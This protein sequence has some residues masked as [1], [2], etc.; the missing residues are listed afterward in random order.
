MFILLTDVM[1]MTSDSC[2]K[3]Q[4]MF[5]FISSII[6]PSKQINQMQDKQ[7]LDSCSPTDIDVRLG[8]G[9]GKTELPN[10]ILKKLTIQHATEF[11]NLRSHDDK[12]SLA[13]TILQKFRL[14]LPNSKFYEMN[15]QDKSWRLISTDATIET[16][17]MRMLRLVRQETEVS[18]MKKSI[19]LTSKIESVGLTEI[20]N[21]MLPLPSTESDS[22]SSHIVKLVDEILVDYENAHKSLIQTTRMKLN[23][24]FLNKT[25]GSKTVNEDAIVQIE[26]AEL[27]TTSIIQD[28]HKK[29]DVIKSYTPPTNLKKTYSSSDSDF[30]LE[31]NSDD[32]SSKRV[33]EYITRA[34]I[35]DKHSNDSAHSVISDITKSQTQQVKDKKLISS[36]SQ[37]TGDFLQSKKKLLKDKEEISSPRQFISKGLHKGSNPKKQLPLLV[38]TKKRKSIQHDY[39]SINSQSDDS[40]TVFD[41]V[42]PRKL[43]EKRKKCEEKTNSKEKG[44]KEAVSKKQNMKNNKVIKR[45]GKV[46]ARK[47]MKLS[48]QQ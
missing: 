11:K 48:W 47:K 46:Q 43:S 37:A 39:N 31:D 29:N 32:A 7:E 23:A 24:L 42:Q 21:P 15:S 16:K 22:A 34:Q 27:E 41:D 1:I 40:L 3:T 35:S 33:V 8:K 5:S 9:F 28:G 4:V 10:Q 18:L 19:C 6:S 26:Q 13:K 12:R 25:I 30:S 14:E 36:Q 2:H 44:V 20:R 45:K 38:N 17:I